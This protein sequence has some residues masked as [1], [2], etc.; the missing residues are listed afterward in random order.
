MIHHV[1]RL[2]MLSEFLGTEIGK[3]FF[4][5]DL[6]RLVDALEKI[7][8]A[9]TKRPEVVSTGACVIGEYCRRHQFIHG[10]EAEEL[11]AKID[12]VL[13]STE[14][15]GVK[16]VNIAT[17]QRVLDDVDARDAISWREHDAYTKT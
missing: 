12:V 5:S 15:S 7:A 2:M 1:K 11:R 13:K 10:A 3:K 14:S 9:V 17:I 16:R 8:E 4:E 6:P